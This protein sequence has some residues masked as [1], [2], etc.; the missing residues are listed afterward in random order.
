MSCLLPERN[1]MILKCE[2]KNGNFRNNY[3]KNKC[4]ENVS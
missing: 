4:N 3:E 1:Y 2:N